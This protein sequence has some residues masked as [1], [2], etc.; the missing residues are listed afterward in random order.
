MSFMKIPT[1]LK[2]PQMPVQ[3][4]EE[5]QGVG[6]D[7]GLV[8]FHSGNA[9]LGPYVIT[10]NRWCCSFYVGSLLLNPVYREVN[11]HI[12]WMKSDNGGN[13]YLYY[14]EKYKWVYIRSVFPGFEPREDY[15]S[16]TREWE[17][18]YFYSGSLPAIKDGA[19]SEFS[20]RGEY[21]NN[22]GASKIEVKPFFP[23]WR[24][25]TLC[26]EY[27][28]A[29]GLTGTRTFGLPRWTD[30]AGNEYVRSIEKEAGE[31]TYGDI[32]KTGDVWT[33]GVPGA[34]SGWYEG[35]EPDKT[36]PVTFRFCKPVGSELEG[37]DRVVTFAGYVIGDQTAAVQLGEVAIW[38]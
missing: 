21:L 23:R 31:F 4:R 2:S 19:V 17:G 1:A 26:G 11:G 33:I 13:Y 37:A 14:T 20:P 10:E 27:T 32:R 12:Y 38:R 28:P 22:S 3:P 8:A 7:A 24:N 18:D 29:D 9:A 30:D 36:A 35:G 25:S 16:D 6:A 34:A 5:W 15:N